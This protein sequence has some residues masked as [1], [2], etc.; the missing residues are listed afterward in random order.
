[1]RKPNSNRGRAN[2]FRE[3]PRPLSPAVY[4]LRKARY[5]RGITASDL[6]DRIGYSVSILQ[7]W[8][9][10]VKTPRAQSLRDWAQGLNIDIGLFE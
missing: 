10:G 7:E 9:T 6:A 5:D 1:M 2:S 3:P 8:E 4:A